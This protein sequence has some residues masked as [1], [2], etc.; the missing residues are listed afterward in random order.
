[1][2]PD[3]R[4]DTLAHGDFACHLGTAFRL[5]LPSGEWLD[6]VLI[7]AAAHPRPAPGAPGRQGFSLVFR[8]ELPGHLPQGIYGLEHAHMG[9]FEIFLVPIGPRQ[10]GMCYEAVFN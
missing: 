9:R 6:L 8:S 10:G 7:E 5:A 1:M 2:N 3:R 4:L